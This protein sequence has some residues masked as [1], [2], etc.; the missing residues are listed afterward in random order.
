MS[1]CSVVVNYADDRCIEL[2]ECDVEQKKPYE[3]LFA[4]GEGVNLI[5]NLHVDG[6][7]IQGNEAIIELLGSNA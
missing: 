7:L 3:E 2:D 6:Q 1:T 4:L 5:S